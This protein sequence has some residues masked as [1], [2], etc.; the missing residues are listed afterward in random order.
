MEHTP[1]LGVP[2]SSASADEFLWEQNFAP[3]ELE[4]LCNHRVGQVSL[5]PGTCYIEMGRAVVRVVHGQT[6]FALTSV[7]FFSI[8]FLDDELDGAPT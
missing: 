2:I 1:F 7:K 4:F 6:G 5:L 8:M 3:H